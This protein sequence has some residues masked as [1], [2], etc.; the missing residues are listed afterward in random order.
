VTANALRLP[1]PLT[2]F[3]APPVAALTN[4]GARRLLD[5]RVFLGGAADAARYVKD[6]RPDRRVATC[7]RFEQ[8]ERE[9]F[10]PATNVDI[11]MSGFLVRAC[12]LLDAAAR[13]RAPVHSTIA[14]PHVGVRD[15]DQISAAVLPPAPWDPATES[16]AEHA[17]RERQSIGAFVRAQGCRVTVATVSELQLRCDDLLYALSELLRADIDGHGDEEIVVSPYLRSLTGTFT[18]P[19]PVVV[20]TRRSRDALLVPRPIT[21]LVGSGG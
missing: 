6:G 16:P 13:A 7:R 15:I 14:A 20:L 8:A 5:V 12:G 3:D 9:G 18:S 10:E 2:Y 4:A 17:R 11:V 19:G 21:P 1:A